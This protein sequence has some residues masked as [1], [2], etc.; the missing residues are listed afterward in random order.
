M[1]ISEFSEISWNST[2]FPGLEYLL[3]TK[4]IELFQKR[5]ETGPKLQLLTFLTIHFSFKSDK[6]SIIF[7]PL[8]I[9]VF[10]HQF[11]HFSIFS[12]N[13]TKFP[14][15][16]TLLKMRENEFFSKPLQNYRNWP[17]ST[18]TFHPSFSKKKL[19]FPEIPHFF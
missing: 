8:K 16:K 6:Y 5:L 11:Q 12:W 1:P 15:S 13:S 17:L 18:A 19:N 10:W 7:K 14:G 9:K 4:K 2:K 3:K